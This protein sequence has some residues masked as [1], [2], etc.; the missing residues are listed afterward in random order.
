MLRFRFLRPPGAKPE[1]EFMARCLHCGQCAEI[2][3][4]DC[5]VLGTGFNPFRSGTP[6]IDPKVSPCRL[7]MRCCAIC[8]SHA[9]E[10]VSVDEVR[11]GEAR[12][13]KDKCHTWGGYIL[14]RSCFER[15]PLK[16][17][18]IALEKGIYPVVTDKCV[19]CGQCEHVCPTS[20]ILTMPARFIS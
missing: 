4:F 16:G 20:A 9:L 1:R 12:I 3:P 11:M 2:C 13:D 15:C 14:C 8:P 5:I 7:C 18:A 17:K 10:N 6:E 19:G